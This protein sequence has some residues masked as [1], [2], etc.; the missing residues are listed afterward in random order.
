[1]AKMSSTDFN[2][3]NNSIKF[4]ENAINT[5]PQSQNAEMRP[6]N[7]RQLQNRLDELKKQADRAEVE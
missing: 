3:L 1:M 7:K 4:Y 6:R 5:H 2:R